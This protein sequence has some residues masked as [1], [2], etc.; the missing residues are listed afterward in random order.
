MSAR[1]TTPKGAHA[2]GRRSAGLVPL[3]TRTPATNGART[4]TRATEARA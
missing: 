1:T 3:P 2:A 4:A